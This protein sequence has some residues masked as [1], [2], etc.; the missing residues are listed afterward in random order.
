M[1]KY[2]IIIMIGWCAMSSNLKNVTQNIKKAIIAHKIITVTTIAFFALT[3]FIT[4]IV[5]NAIQSQNQ[6]K[7]VEK[8]PIKNLEEEKLKI[9]I[10]NGLGAIPSLSECKRIIEDII[11]AE[12]DLNVK[13]ELIDEEVKNMINGQY[14]RAK[15]MLTLHK[16]GHNALAQLLME[17][18]VIFADDMERIFGKRPWVSRSEEIMNMK[19]QDAL[20]DENKEEM[21]LLEDKEA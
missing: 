15:E 13:A 16:E 11:R 3:I 14:E 6:A 1:Q 5:I 4:P 17:K 21:P 20:P 8:N 2:D 12:F 7:L 19:K 10:K 9:Y 18:E